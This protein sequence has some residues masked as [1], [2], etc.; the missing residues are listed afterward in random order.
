MSLHPFFVA[1][2]G[3]SRGFDDKKRNNMKKLFIL[4]CSSM[5]LYYLCTRNDWAMV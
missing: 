2:D 1:M 4:F 3:L 5:N